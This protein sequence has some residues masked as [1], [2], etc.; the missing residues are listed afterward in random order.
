MTSLPQYL[1]ALP[2]ML[3]MAL[4]AWG[5]ATRRRNVGLVDIFWS[6]FL[7]VAAL[8]YLGGQASVSRRALLV[9]TLVAL[10]ALR[11][12]LHLGLRNWNAP[13]DHRYQAIRARNQ[14]GFEWKSLYLVFGLQAVLALLVAAPLYASISAP[15]R[16]LQLLD[17]VGAAVVLVGI[18]VESLADLQLAAFRADASS[19]GR[20]MDS[21]LWRYSRH[22]NYFGEF[23]V[24]WGF[25]LIALA[26]GAWWTLVSPLLMS[27]LLLRVSGVT[28]LEQ[29]IGTRR[30]GYAEYVARTNAFFPG[31][32]KAA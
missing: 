8:S 32:R 20:V 22:P 4:L 10:W 11:L 23:C 3:A 31:P 29:D 26:T 25:F 7:L 12:A 28:L 21:G 14:P 2:W 1:G 17:F 13:E 15:A 18:V 5:V 30:P 19:R 9:L 16:S 24:W 27:L 6:L